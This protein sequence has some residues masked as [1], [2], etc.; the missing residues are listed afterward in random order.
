MT[1]RQSAKVWLTG[2]SIALLAASVLPGCG[3]ESATN[4]GA[5]SPSK[6]PAAS[7]GSSPAANTAPVKVE[8][9]K[10]GTSASTPIPTPDFLHDGILSA[11]GV[12]LTLNL[13]ATG[14]DLDNKINVLAASNDLPDI[15]ETR[16]RNVYQQLVK[17]GLLLDLTPYES[18]LDGVKKL[19]GSGFESGRINGKLYGIARPGSGQPANGWI[20][21]DWLD[22]LGLA[23][24]AN[25]DELLKVAKA[26]TENDPDGNGK[27]DTFGITGSV[28]GGNASVFAPILLSYGVSPYYNAFYVRDSKLYNSLYDPNM[29]TALEQI[30]Q[31]ISE[32]VVDPEFTSNKPAAAKDKAHKGQAGIVYDAWPSLVRDE[33]VQVIKAANPN[34]EWVIIPE[35][36]G[37]AYNYVRSIDQGA[38][39]GYI[40]LP[41]RLEKEPEKL[42]KILHM[43]NFLSDGDGLLLAQYGLKDVHY[44][45]EGSKAVMTDKATEAGFTTLYQLIGRNEKEYLN[46]KFPKQASYINQAFAMPEMKTVNQLIDKPADY[47]ATDA[48]RYMQEEMLKFFYSKSNLTTDY[49]KFLQDLGSKFNFSKMQEAA[50]KQMKEQGVLK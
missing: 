40:M 11:T 4:Q 17:N 31:F 41:K 14:T 50:E 49:D 5:A 25:P 7:G 15:V 1:K 9:L 3:K 38:T 36:K 45:L 35:F 18:K 43:L 6:A 19:A 22:K 37:T 21:K 42:E 8:I 48:E 24:P 32:G 10:L 29:R 26:F 47:T 13:I 30:R 12:D 16:N 33:S 44:K 28:E 39:S 46:T 2:L 34:A 27:K 20:R 23:M